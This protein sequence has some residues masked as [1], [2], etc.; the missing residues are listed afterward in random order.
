MT[1]SNDFVDIIL[2]NYNK[3]LY[4]KEAVDSVI[5]QSFENWKLYII[6]DCSTDK[7]IEVLKSYME[8]KK[9]IVLKLAKNQG[10]SFC[11]NLGLRISNSNFISFLDSDDYW[12]KDKLKDQIKFMKD[13]NLSFTYTDYIPFI[14]SEKTKKFIKKTSIQNSLNFNQ[15]VLNSSINTTTMII[16]RSILKNLKFKKIEKLEDYLFKCQILKQNI[17]AYKFNSSSAFYRILKKSRSSQRFNNILYLW[18]INQKYNNFSFIKNL[19][20]IFM[21]SLNSIKKYG[22]K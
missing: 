21:I 18:K 19:F 5:N 16:S 10:P 4:L 7:S 11:R 20:S 17:I 13:K 22:L 15:F 2:P 1:N 3:E 6:D 8:N 12:E 14:Q 9:I